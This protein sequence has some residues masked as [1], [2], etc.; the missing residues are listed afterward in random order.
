VLNPSLA[1]FYLVIV[2]QFVPRDAPFAWSVLTLTLVHISMAAT[3]HA[4]WAVAG[5]TL[6]SA[7]SR[8]RPRQLLDAVTG[9][10]LIWVAV[11]IAV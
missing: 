5:A 10:A 4:A 8:R 11:R 2:P 1:A 3:W 6:A 7:L 9:I